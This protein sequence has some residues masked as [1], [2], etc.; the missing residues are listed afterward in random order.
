MNHLLKLL[1][2]IS[3]ITTIFTYKNRAHVLNTNL[4]L[5]WDFIDHDTA[6]DVKI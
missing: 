2:L 5:Y 1:T 3:L 4:T 6:I